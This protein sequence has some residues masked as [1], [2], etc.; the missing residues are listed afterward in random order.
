MRIK[1]QHLVLL[2]SIIFFL[3]VVWQIQAYLDDKVKNTIFVGEKVDLDDESALRALEMKTT[4]LAMQEDVRSLANRLSR[5]CPKEMLTDDKLFDDKG[6][7]S[8]LVTRQLSPVLKSFLQDLQLSSEEGVTKKQSKN[9][10]PEKVYTWVGIMLADQKR[11]KLL[12]ANVPSQ[13]G[14]LSLKEAD[15]EEHKNYLQLYQS[16]CADDN[17][18]EQEGRYRV[19]L[20]YHLET[21][22]NPRELLGAVSIPG[23]N[24]V[25]AVA[26]DFDRLLARAT[27]AARMLSFV[28]DHSGALIEYPRDVLGPGLEGEKLWSIAPFNQP[29]LTSALKKNPQE[30]FSIEEK[31]WQH[32]VHL[33]PIKLPNEFMDSST[34]QPDMQAVKELVEKVNEWNLESKRNPDFRIKT[35]SIEYLNRPDLKRFVLRASEQTLQAVKNDLELNTKLSP[36]L[37]PDAIVACNEFFFRVVPMEFDPEDNPGFSVLFVQGASKEEILSSYGGVWQL[38]ILAVVLLVVS[39]LT[40]AFFVSWLRTSS[41]RRLTRAA[42]KISQGDFNVKV[43]MK[44]KE[45]LSVVERAIETMVEEVNKKTSELKESEARHKAILSTAAEGI[46]TFEADGNLESMNKAAERLLGWDTEEIR[47]KSVK[48]FFAQQ[49]GHEDIDPLAELEEGSF[50][51]HGREVEGRRKDGSTF[52]MEIAI[53]QVQLP[54]RVIATAIVRD[55]TD[56]KKIEQERERINISLDHKV[57][58]ATAELQ[59][60]NQEL[61]GAKEATENAMKAQEVFLNNVA[62]DLRTPLTVVIGYS[63]ELYDHALK[64][65]HE[66]YLDDLH[67]IVN[68][69]NDLRELIDDLLNMSKAI[70]G[71]ELPLEL[72]SFDVK[73]MIHERMA[74]L[75]HLAKRNKNKLILETADNLGQMRADKVRVWRII[76]NLLSNALKFTRRG[77]VKLVAEREESENGGLIRFQII[78]TGRGI[79]KE[80]QKKL[81]NRFEQVRDS[82]GKT[83][84]GGFGLG[85]SI[86]ALYCRIMGGTIAVKSEEGKGST[87]TVRLPVKA[88]VQEVN[89]VPNLKKSL[90]SKKKTR[91]PDHDSANMVLIIDDDTSISELMR[92]NLQEEG[93]ATCTAATGEEG[94]KLAREILPSA[95]ILDVVL[96]GLDGWAVLAALKTDPA[97]SEIPIIMASMLDEKQRGLEMGADEYVTKPF[98]RDKLSALIHKHVPAPDACRHALVVEDDEAIRQKIAKS[99]RQEGWTVQEAEDGKIAMELIEAQPPCLILL[100]LLLPVMDGFQVIEQIRKHPQWKHIP[101]VVITHVDLD[102]ETRAKLQGKVQNILSKELYGREELLHEVRNLVHQVESQQRQQEGSNA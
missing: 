14:Q 29:E 49:E 32:T 7:L 6:N 39:S 91:K 65:G 47:G 37:E 40:V 42:S 60:A 13:Q 102:A 28:A 8:P 51:S 95:I 76:M 35:P 46:I 67:L 94:L 48:M 22:E 20:A 12:Y 11:V 45:Q 58:E 52:P 33:M 77:E 61:L 75:E 81:F 85:L 100:D 93:M 89:I 10:N 70:S 73:E 17:K 79:P 84:G 2:F 50:Y 21:G 99:L 66:E 71:K 34:G 83:S 78:D 44:K 55:I 92:R 82:S 57:R 74:G 69:G 53:S 56:R 36:Y 86:C 64:Q 19:A 30:P 5:S 87:F 97:T 80:E 9:K 31:P 90:S 43:S 23:T 27:F 88:E 98:S 59:Q 62:H 41:L 3:F 38:M 24:H 26:L 4:V 15:R 63:Q 16:I 1:L 101:V 68:R 96:P 18:P 25:V 72:T 54:N